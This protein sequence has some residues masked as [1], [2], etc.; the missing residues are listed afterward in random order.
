MHTARAAA[1]GGRLLAGRPAAGQLAS[2]LAGQQ[3]RRS[4]SRGGYMGASLLSF[5]LTLVTK[6]HHRKDGKW[7]RDEKPIDSVGKTE[8]NGA[9]RFSGGDFYITFRQFSRVG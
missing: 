5:C 8:A 9:S 3:R 6:D 2:W 4:D 1:E 7:F